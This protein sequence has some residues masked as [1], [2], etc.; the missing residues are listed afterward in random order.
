MTFHRQ[1]NIPENIGNGEIGGKARGLVLLKEIIDRNQNRLRF[2]NL[3]IHVPPFC[4]LRTDLF[5]QFISINRLRSVIKGE[6]SEE[7][8]AR[9]FFNAALPATVSGEM[10]RILT[11]LRSPL[12]IRSSSLLEDQLATPFAGVYSTKM[13]PNLHSDKSLRFRQAITAIKWIY[14]ST[15]FRD[16]VDYRRSLDIP[17]QAEA[18][19]V[20]VQLIE[21]MRH[22]DR[23]YP[24]FSGVA[25]SVNLYPFGNSTP[26]DGLVSLALGLGK[27]IVDG[28]PVWTYNPRSPKSPPPFASAADRLKNTQHRFWAVDMRGIH[29]YNPYVDHEYM[30][31]CRLESAEEDNTLSLSASTFDAPNDRLVPGIGQPGPR[32]IDFAP[33]LEYDMLPVNDALLRIMELGEAYYKTPVEI[34]F[35]ATLGF[36]GSDE[37]NRLGILQIRPMK[38]ARALPPL[39]QK[40]GRNIIL[41]SSRCLGGG[42]YAPIRDILVMNRADLSR[43]R[44]CAVEISD[45]NRK[46]REENRP[47]L[48]VG[49]GRWGS[50]D[51][52]LGVGVNWSQICG[53]RGIVEI[54]PPEQGIEFSQGSHFFHNLINLDIPYLFVPSHRQDRFDWTWLKEQ[55]IIHQG[56]QITHYRARIPVQMRIDGINQQGVIYHDSH[57]EQP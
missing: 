35:A 38:Q 6:M 10:W 56:D 21:G 3:Q 30:M 25:R 29:P 54:S 57:P 47:Y 51:P 46:L 55:E 14:A 32:V 28:A 49:Y 18:M 43:S 52:W 16:A 37:P 8:I 31:D 53:T 45:L 22:S 24:H 36:P 41:E 13:I 40:A 48:L 2:P 12:A 20:I 11:G 23:F 42:E 15:F 33:M 1:L 39:P 17:E 44:Q 19:A 4:I 9:H 5:G 26:Q 27:T 50:S 34:E 7:Q